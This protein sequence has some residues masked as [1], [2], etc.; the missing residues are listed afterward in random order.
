MDDN[1]VSSSCA[2]NPF[3]SE[4]KNVD[5]ENKIILTYR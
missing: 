5:R 3:I 1:K 2:A 4:H